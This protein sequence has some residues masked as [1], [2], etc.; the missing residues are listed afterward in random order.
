M[1]QDDAKGERS[2]ANRSMSARHFSLSS[3]AR[4][5]ADVINGLDKELGHVLTD[6]R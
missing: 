4:F 3:L 5:R 2:Y 1:R 6:S